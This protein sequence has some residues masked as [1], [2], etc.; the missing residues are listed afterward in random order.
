VLESNQLN[1]NIGFPVGVWSVST[2]GDCEGR[3]TRDLGIYY[4]HVAEI[5]FYLRNKREYSLRFSPSKTNIIDAK[6]V[7]KL[8]SEDLAKPFEATTSISLDIKSGTWPSDL[9]PKDRPAVI[10]AWLEQAPSLVSFELMDDVYYCSVLIKMINKKHK[11]N[12]LKLTHLKEMIY[13]QEMA[14][15]LE[16]QI[17]TL[18]TTTNKKDKELKRHKQIIK[19]FPKARTYDRLG[20]LSAEEIMPLIPSERIP[21]LGTKVRCKSLRLQCF[22]QGQI[23]VFCGI[24][25]TF[26]AVE[27]AGNQDG[28]HINFYAKDEYGNDVLMTRDHI[29]PTS[30]GGPDTLENSQTMCYICN[31]IKGNNE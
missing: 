3:T 16:E 29:I 7:K 14:R 13:H 22:K 17:R 5:S 24:E 23:C 12:N 11:G 31:E 30:K 27:R 25:G 26:F 18:K 20:T 9:N 15:T 10:Q 21:V 8:L 28:Y 2:E 1:D 6:D 4:G 19:S